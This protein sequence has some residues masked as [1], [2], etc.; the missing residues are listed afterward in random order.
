MSRIPLRFWI[1]ATVLV[2]LNAVGL[3]CIR[4]EIRAGRRAVRIVAAAPTSEVDST[5]R[6]SLTFDEPLA[7]GKEAGR[8]LTRSPFTVTP[9]LAGQ[10]TWVAPQR[11]EFRLDAPLPPGRVFTVR[12]AADAEAQLGRRLAGETVFQFKTRTL[13]LRAC[14]LIGVDREHATFEL[15]FNQPVNPPDLLR[16]MQVTD[17]DGGQ[18]LDTAILTSEPAERLVVRTARPRREHVRLTLDQALTGNN[19]ELPLGAP[20]VQQLKVT[21]VFAILRAAV[22]EPAL[23]QDAD[24]TLWFTRE[25]DRKQS[26]PPVKV[27][28][29][30]E[31]LRPRLE[32]G[33]LILTGR[34]ES[35]RRYTATV[36]ETLLSEAGETLSEPQ[37]VSFEVP[38]RRPTVLFPL[39]EGILSPAGNTAVEVE[40]VNVG[41]LSVNVSRLHANNL[42]SALHHRRAVEE[43]HRQLPERTLP[44]KLARNVP[45]KMLLDLR[46]LVDRP[47]GVFNVAAAATDREWT[48][49][50]AIVMLTDLGL[51]VKQER[52]GLLAWVTSLRTAEP[53][54]GVTVTAVSQNNQTLGRGVTDASGLVH[55]NIP[56]KHPDGEVWLVTA[57]RDGDMSFLRPERRP[58]VLDDVDQSG[59]GAPTTYD[60]LLY[61]ERGVYRRGDTVHLTGI[62]R[63]VAGQVP[64]AFPLVVRV[65]RPDGRNVSEL[66]VNRHADD[67]GVFHCD[68][69]TREDGQL[70]KYS[71]AVTLP[72]SQDALGELKVLVEEFVPVRIAVTAVAE[73]PRFGPGETP[74]IGVHA[75]YLFDQPA[76]G[77]SLTVIGE[78][79]RVPYKS[80][81]FAR[82]SFGAAEQKQA[83]KIPEIETEL[84]DE[85]QADVDL[86]VPEGEVA[87]W[88]EGRVA[89]TVT[90]PGGRSVSANVPVVVDTADRYVGLH[91]PADRVVSTQAGPVEVEWVFVNGSDEPATGK[92]KLSLSRV[93]HE[94]VV[95]MVEKRPV[96]KSVERL[97]P[98]W[99][100]E[101]EAADNDEP[102]VLELDVKDAAQYRLCASDSESGS[103]SS[104]EFYASSNPEELQTIALNRPERL[105]IVLDKDSYVPG[106]TAEVLIRSPFPGR[107]LLTL[108]T[109]RVVGQRLVSLTGNTANVSLPVPAW[110]RGGAFVSATMVRGVDPA[111]DKWLPHRAVG[112]ARLITD[113]R[114]Q[115]LPIRIVAPTAVRPGAL[116]SVRVESEVP[117]PARPVSSQPTTEPSSQ[118]ATSQAHDGDE[119]PASQPTETPAVV[120]LWAVDE[121]ILRTTAYA[122]PDPL[123]HFFGRRQ[124]QVA[125]ADVFGDLLPDY[126]R[127]AGMIHIGADAGEEDESLRRSPV[128]IPRRPP[129]V[130]WRVSA[131][132]GADG[133]LTVPMELP[134]ITGEVRLMAVAVA[135]DRYGTAEQPVTLATP[136]LVEAAWP[137]FAAPDDRF[138]VPVKLFN[139]SGQQL[140]ATIELDVDGPL[141]VEL[142]G[143]VRHI[144]VASG[145]PQTVWLEAVATAMG[146]V[147]VKV[148]ATAT[149]AGGEELVETS[150][151]TFPIRPIAPLVAETK[152]IRVVAGEET[153]IELPG[154]F[155]PGTGRATL[156][157]SGQP[158]VELLPALDQL[159]EYPYGCVEQTSSRLYALLG[160]PDLL[161]AAGERPGRVD[162]VRDMVN[163]GLLRLW[164]M[165][166][167]DGGLSYW[168]GGR[169][170]DL[171]PSAYVGQLLLA[172]RRAG[173]EPERRF[174]E[175]LLKYLKANLY[176]SECA[177]EEDLRATENQRAMICYVLAGFGKPEEGWQA[178]LSE[179]PDRL[180]MAGRAHLAAAWM[181]MGRKDRARAAL[182]SDTIELTVGNPH[183]ISSAS[184]VYQQ[185]T[186]LAV[187]LDLDRDHAWIPV[188]VG[189]LE[190]ARKGGCWGMTLENATALA[191]LARYQAASGEPAEFEGEIVVG[192]SQRFSF[193]SE[194]PATA[195]FKW[196]AGPVRLTSSGTGSIFVTAQ[197][198]GLAVDRRV[199]LF[200]RQLEVRRIW[201]DRNGATIDPAALRVGDAVC[202]EITLTAPGLGTG[203]VIENIAIVD[204]LPGG[205]EVEHPALVTSA[206]SASQVGQGGEPDRVEFR[207][208]RVIIFTS[209]TTSRRSFRYVLRVITAGQFAIPPLE[210]SCMYNPAMASRHGG[211]SLK[212]ER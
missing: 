203:D 212:V 19:A 40:A 57:E 1:L 42:V 66:Q 118:P 137:R 10:W 181:E 110:L 14:N 155:L 191:A 91:L 105:E 172:A 86:P 150:E 28:P 85:G 204:P 123:K 27:N 161:A 153:A 13:E 201:T 34:F 12:A 37:T 168:P 8:P 157:I 160:A 165:Q 15:V 95:K 146:P 84:D 167:R 186:L 44:L 211:G 207:D 52:D 116:V 190:A 122:T 56:D 179:R 113:H 134:K 120:H 35:N 192:E 117:P 58:W 115:A 73:Q 67:Q 4:A 139:T 176:T 124:L 55:L 50:S 24:V 174:V 9:A 132:V 43:T 171:W 121:G 189:K 96:W 87:G 127:P 206:N 99:K 65:T 133:T 104:I 6:L 130:V 23:E 209:A 33:R 45:A 94:S 71:F 178:R 82:F 131:P 21:P 11:L 175:E 166:T 169:Q 76:A 25:L 54:A 193:D 199:E 197:T 194:Q 163:A 2:V 107:L 112:L 111:Q 187:L 63:D 61:G 72:G 92:I 143:Q 151:A 142:P 198:R 125:S 106:S 32:A 36:A 75:R 185:A 103:T 80:A 38:D 46:E 101:V 60:V 20:V 162:Q 173:Y 196:D 170:S 188:L 100:G 77:L 68:Y 200:D 30:V 26:L 17:V 31:G 159:L 183:G 177:N 144:A 16:L 119:V 108:E 3:F 69:P 97:V 41:G 180:D 138:E 39:S 89:A 195:R 147:S 64:P 154:E 70:G 74:T 78:L 49:S 88:W 114:S 156:T 59:R 81:K 51:T 109:D 102:Q 90:E 79:Q 129:A 7:E 48:S 93:E 145:M 83:W 18:K 126:R 22:D 136:L 149:L 158:Q 148:T 98:V 202:V 152:F 62:I 205:M 135:G 140:D 53:V 182:P 184:Q 29:A 208:D 210:A 141:N 47:M 128:S 5:D 164:S